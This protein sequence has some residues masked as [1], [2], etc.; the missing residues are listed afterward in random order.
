MALQHRTTDTG[1]AWKKSCFILSE[2]PDFHIVDNL[3]IA[4]H[5]LP[6]HMLISL[7]V[8]KILLPS[9]FNL[10]IAENALTM[11]MLILLSVDKILRP[12]YFNLSIAVNALPMRMLISLSVDKILLPMYFNLSIAVNALPMRMLI[13]LSVD[14]ILLPRYMNLS[15]AFMLYQWVYW[16]QWRNCLT[17]LT[18]SLHKSTTWILFF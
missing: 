18:N 15:I 1:T 8:D 14:E 3:S 16:H 9:Y 17:T 11:R 2:R 10:S 13:S 4:V 5:G 7:S 12:R 6:M